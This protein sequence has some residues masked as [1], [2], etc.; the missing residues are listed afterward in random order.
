[1]APEKAAPKKAAAKK[2]APEKTTAKKAAPEKTTAKK[3]AAKKAAPDKT[4]PAK[5]AAKNAPAKKAP[6]K[7][8]APKKAPAEHDH[9]HDHEHDHEHEHEHELT[10]EEQAQAE[11][12]VA[13]MGEALAA[14]DDNALRAALSTMGEK[15][16]AEL[17]GV[18]NLPR[19]TMHLG[20][21]LVPLVRRKLRTAAPDHQL[22]VL[23][24]L[25]DKANDETIQALGDKSEDPSRDD[26][27]AVL[28]QVLEHH[29][30]PL[31]TAMLAGYAASDAV[32]RPVMRDLLDTDERFAIG[33]P[34]AV[35]EKASTLFAPPPVVDKE[36]LAAKREQRRSAKEAKHAAEQRA[37]EA[38]ANAEVKRRDALHKSKRKSH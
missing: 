23:F 9:A 7:K 35:E 19:A 21:A 24:A 33:P 1:M 5:A 25:A 6:A 10:P 38:R 17:A 27:L 26:L 2:A 30:Q 37:K 15:S 11:A 14:I 34:V 20:D 28:P 16:R 31:V 3:A 12:D 8:A 29:P 18:L 32:C 4:P 13:R 22:Q 36:A